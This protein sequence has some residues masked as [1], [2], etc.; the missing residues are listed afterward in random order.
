MT[1][2]PF[3][4]SAVTRP[5]DTARGLPN[6]FYTD[7]S[8]FE[9]EKERVFFRNWAALG[10]VSDVP[11]PRDAKPVTF[12]GQPLV[13][14]RDRDGTLRVF[15]NICRHRGMILV[16]QEGKIARAVRCPYHSWCYELNGNLRTTPHVGGPGTNRHDE[17]KREELGLFEVR[18]HIWMGVVFVNIDGKA[19]PFEQYAADAIAR[20]KDFDKPLYV[21]GDEGSFKMDV[22][23]NWKLAIENG[24]ESYHL[25]WVHPGLNSYSRLEDHY[26]IETPAAY[27]GQGTTVY[28]P[29]LDESGRTFP[30]FEGLGEKWGMSAEYPMFFPNIMVGF[31]R[32]HFWGFIVEPIAH[33]RSREHVQ[34]FYTSPDVADDDYAA[35]R[36]KNA[37]MWAEVFAEDIFV[38]EGMQQGRAASMFDGGK[39]SPVMDNPTHDFHAW[40]ATQMQA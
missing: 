28:N 10:F 3:D 20:Y 26:H 16:Q 34:I 14:I 36:R 12:L 19:P 2:F 11:E 32:D 4:L 1:A 29:S 31:Q 23:A 15:Q 33:N 18:S 38:V 21:C 8:V 22:N 17:I 37:D 39:F 27:S 35:M 7:P 24:A 13:M 30:A 5:I 9:A 6:P 25:P 40:V